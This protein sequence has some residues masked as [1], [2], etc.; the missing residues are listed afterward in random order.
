M[1]SIKPTHKNEKSK[2]R[3]PAPEPVVQ[4]VETAVPELVDQAATVHRAKLFPQKLSSGEVQRLQ[5]TLGNQ[6]VSKLLVSKSQRPVVQRQGDPFAPFKHPDKGPHDLRLEPEYDPAPPGWVK[7][8]HDNRDYYYDVKK[9]WET[10]HPVILER[11][12][13]QYA[14]QKFKDAIKE[15]QNKLI[16]ALG[17]RKKSGIWQQDGDFGPA[18]ERAVKRFQKAEKLAETGKA[19]YDTW[20]KLDEKG[21]V[22]VSHGRVSYAYEETLVGST[23]GTY[24]M[25]ASYGWAEKEKKLEVTVNIKFTN[26]PGEA[27]NIS[28]WVQNLWNIFKISYKKDKDGQKKR[29][30]D[31]SL[32]L[33]FVVGT[34]GGKKGPV[35]HPDNQVLLWRGDHPNW[36]NRNAG[37]PA[38]DKKTRSD[39]GNWWLDDPGVQTMVGHEF[40]HLIGLEDEYARSH[41][42]ITRITGNTP[43]GTDAKEALSP[44]QKAKYDQLVNAI[45]SA[46]DIKALQAVNTLVWDWHLSPN[47]M[48]FL[49][50][51]YKKQTGNNLDKTFKQA[52]TDV[53]WKVKKEHPD[54]SDLL[55]TA[56]SERKA[57]NKR[58]YK[59]L[60]D[61]IQ[62]QRSTE[63]WQEWVGKFPDGVARNTWWPFWGAGSREYVSGGLMGDYSLLTSKK[64]ETRPNAVAHSHTHP[65][66]PRHVR[67][68]AEYVSRYKNEVWEAEYR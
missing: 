39:G 45:T 20:A 52:V 41:A 64:P 47:Q 59:E 68:F 6:A 42:D 58:S 67:R 46:K 10:S 49:A 17:G 32:D 56:R 55:K 22:G 44:D 5:R 14:E 63:V 18:T 25:H 62:T 13:H 35:V 50:Q 26:L 24:G 8:Q 60:V 33:E 66:E 21:A 16:V 7:K 29:T 37:W 4:G 2:T 54:F 40:G 23:P 12:M 30:K 3:Q 51:E 57:G 9:G 43:L 31:T 48:E 61:L 38:V 65:L 1:P 53:Y 15:L 19:D 11:D 27:G 28:K 34:G 36:K